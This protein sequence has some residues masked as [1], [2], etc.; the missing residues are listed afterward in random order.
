MTEQLS[1]GITKGIPGKVSDGVTRINLS[2]P[3]TDHL[4][5]SKKHT[6]I[7]MSGDGAVLGINTELWP[8]PP[9]TLEREAQA[10][11]EATEHFLDT[12][13]EVGADGSVR[14]DDKAYLHQVESEVGKA[15]DNA[16][17][18]ESALVRAGVLETLQHFQNEFW[19]PNIG[20]ITPIIKDGDT[21]APSI[22]GYRLTCEFPW[23]IR[24]RTGR[25]G[26]PRMVPIVAAS[27][28]T[29][30]YVPQG[31]NPARWPYQ[32]D[33]HS[34]SAI[35]IS[36]ELDK[37]VVPDFKY[38]QP[39]SDRRDMRLIG[40]NVP[41]E[42]RIDDFSGLHGEHWKQ[43]DDVTSDLTHALLDYGDFTVERGISV[44]KLIELGNQR[45]R[46]LK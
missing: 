15:R 7:D 29:M 19:G 46:K 8:E 10:W 28:V 39:S 12:V 43:N 22:Q 9:L 44:P 38:G 34:A 33:E 18:V 5:E 40:R 20:T 2:R 16:L 11:D 3:L 1:D 23:S 36:A 6:V 21:L 13:I 24:V 26:L 17:S 37:R 25:L 27:S 14:V 31:L 42:S 4:Q 41:L 35:A 30:T 45:V 32:F